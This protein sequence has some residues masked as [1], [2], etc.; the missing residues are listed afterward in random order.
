MADLVI[1]K[2]PQPKKKKKGSRLTRVGGSFFRPWAAVSDKE[3]FVLCT[4]CNAEFLSTNATGKN[5]HEE[6]ETHKKF[7]EEYNDNIPKFTGEIKKERHYLSKY[8]ENAEK[9]K[10]FEYKHQN[11]CLSKNIFCHFFSNIFM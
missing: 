2:P 8:Q 3:G 1:N 5:G 11:L 10:L 9:K 6:T 7:A 4:W